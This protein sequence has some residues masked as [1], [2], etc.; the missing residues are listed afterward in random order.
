MQ[1]HHRSQFSFGERLFTILVQL[2][3][4]HKQT[5][6]ATNPKSTVPTTTLRPSTHCLLQLGSCC[7]CCCC[8]CRCC[9]VCERGESPF[10]EHH[11]T[12]KHKYT[13]THDNGELCSTSISNNKTTAT[14]K[15]KHGALCFTTLR[16]LPLHQSTHHL[17]PSCTPVIVVA[18]AAAVVVVVC[19]C[20]CCCCFSFFCVVV[21]VVVVDTWQSLP[22]K[23]MPKPTSTLQPYLDAVR[24][25][26]SAA[27]CLQNFA[28][29]VV[30]RHN[31][32]EVEVR[33]V[34]FPRCALGCV[35]D[36]AGAG[37]A[38]KKEE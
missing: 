30:E 28:S 32:P 2:S 26:L 8:C 20:C 1:L 36:G 22:P 10:V 35:T 15:T 18:A 17:P 16:C 11:F 33:F 12:H 38:Q 23:P 29:Q 31:K 25:S 37:R 14:I 27:M 9:S 5:R 21:V 3:S 34:T 19:C 6:E 24:S 4:S 13:K 7:C